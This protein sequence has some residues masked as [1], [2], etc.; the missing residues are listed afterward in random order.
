[1]SLENLELVTK[2]IEAACARPKPD[3][4]TVN[5]LFAPDHVFVPLGATKLGEGEARGAEGYREWLRETGE[6][7]QWEADFDGAVDIG[8]HTVLASTTN[9]FAGA[10][11]GI[12][13]EQRFWMLVTVADG[14]VARTEAYMD[15]AEALEAARSAS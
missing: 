7:L 14:K 2:A 4:D 3:F 15:P 11:S 5:E 6:T 10:G 12:Q 13:I 9:R 8:P 1:V